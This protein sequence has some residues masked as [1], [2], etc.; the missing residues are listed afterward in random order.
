MTYQAPALLLVGAAKNLVLGNS[1]SIE[2][3]GECIQP[4]D[5]PDVVEWRRES[6]DW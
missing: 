6:S 5:N 2:V 4:R 1:E 3:G